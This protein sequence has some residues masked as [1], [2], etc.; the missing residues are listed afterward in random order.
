MEKPLFQINFQFRQDIRL[1]RNTKLDILT[2]LSIPILKTQY[3]NL[4]KEYRYSIQEESLINNLHFNLLKI[5]T[6]GRVWITSTVYVVIRVAPVSYC[7]FRL[8]SLSLSRRS[9][10]FLWYYNEMDVSVKFYVFCLWFGFILVE[11]ESGKGY[12]W[13][14]LFNFRIWFLRLNNLGP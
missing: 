1:P 10:R 12:A 6:S 7:W 8:V 3:L 13:R 14:R 11:S 2:L 5:E 4:T 9:W